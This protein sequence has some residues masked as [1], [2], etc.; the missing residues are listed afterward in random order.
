[1]GHRVQGCTEE[2]GSWKEDVFSSQMARAETWEG[3]PRDGDDAL[4]LG[5][6][7]PSHG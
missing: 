6:T 1:M 3:L 5:G 7:H 4:H 2:T